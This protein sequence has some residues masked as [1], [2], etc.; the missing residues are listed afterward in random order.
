M[1]LLRALTLSHNQLEKLGANLF[2][3]VSILE[4]VD[5]SHNRITTIQKGTFKVSR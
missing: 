4:F 1:P 2:T 3:G 5:L